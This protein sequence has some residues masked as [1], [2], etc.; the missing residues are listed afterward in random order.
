MT[1]DPQT[2]VIVPQGLKHLLHV[3]ADYQ[4]VICIGNGCGYA[5]VLSTKQ[6]VKH[7]RMHGVSRDIAVEA[8]SFIA[9]LG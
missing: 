9:G 6:W 3:N 4:K 1:A 7:F 8:S 2:E 5:K